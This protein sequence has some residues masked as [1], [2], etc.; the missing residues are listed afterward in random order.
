MKFE[1]GDIYLDY[2][3]TTPVDPSVFEAMVPYYKRSFGNP[4]SEHRQGHSTRAAVLRARRQVASLLQCEPDEVIFTSGGS[5]SNNLIMKGHAIQQSSRGRHMVISAV[6]HPA[7]TQVAEYLTKHG[8]RV[9]ILPVDGQGLVS[10]ED[11]EEIITSK[12]ILVSVMHANNEVGTIQPIQ[13]LAQIAH[14]HGALFHTD[15]AQSVGKIA[16]L[17][18]DLE[19]DALSI[20]GHKLYAPKG[21]GALYLKRGIKIEPLI[22]GANHENGHRA[23]TENVAQIVGLGAAA[24][25]AKNTIQQEQ[26]RIAGLRARLQT[27]LKLEFPQLRINAQGVERLPN[28]L[29]ISFPDLNALDLMGKLE[30]LMVSAGAACHSGDGKGSGVLEAMGVPLNYQ[31]GTLRLSLG[32]YCDNALVDD[33]L[34]IF[35]SAI[36]SEGSH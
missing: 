33:V 24:E 2:N 13:E 3:A 35:K 9:S 21:V 31:L 20:A 15:A 29:S 8:F 22:H 11:L 10:P 23:G 19:C 18:D 16:T 28:T 5:E 34:K 30:K 26:E 1:N 17:V 7:I 12:T 6:E 14:T 36:K 27:Q 25:L 4:S 32:R